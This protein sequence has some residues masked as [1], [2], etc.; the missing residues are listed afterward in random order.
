MHGLHFSSQLTS[1]EHR[2]ER[3]LLEPK[4]L[5]GG[6]RGGCV[7]ASTLGDVEGGERRETEKQRV[8]PELLT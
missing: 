6:D 5:G 3:L 1:R 4:S 8:T 2:G 7:K